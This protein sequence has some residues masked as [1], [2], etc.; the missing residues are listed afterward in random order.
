MFEFL[1]GG[2]IIKETSGQWE[3]FYKNMLRAM[4]D[5]LKSNRKKLYKRSTCN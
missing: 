3:K 5:T 1:T 2:L 4:T